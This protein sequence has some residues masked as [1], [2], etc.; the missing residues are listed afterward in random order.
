LI[1]I[2]AAFPGRGMLHPNKEASMTSST[3]SPWTAMTAWWRNWRA[4]RERLDELDACGGELAR[5]AR[6]V[7][8]APA[9]LYTIAAKRPG[10][11]DQL[12]RRLKALHLD[13][14]GLQRDDPL[15][16]RDLER[17]CS[18]CGSKRR[19]ERDLARFPDDAV[20]RH[21]CPN[22]MTLDALGSGP[23]AKESSCGCAESKSSAAA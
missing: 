10:A 7:G 6:D 11:A 5:I 12:K 2:K 19:C 9:E 13:P 21:Y 14:T 23:A 18:V 15:I 4:A 3:G 22:A 16:M 17:V 1:Q 20:W 8:V